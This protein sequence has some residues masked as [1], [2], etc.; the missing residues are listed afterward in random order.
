M[1]TPNGKTL[2]VHFFT[3]IFEHVEEI[4]QFQVV[5]HAYDDIEIRYIPSSCFNSVCLNDIKKE[6]WNK[7]NEEFQLRFSKVDFIAPSPSGKPQIVESKLEFR[8]YYGVPK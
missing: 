1:Y 7:A 4:R 5:Q 6:I 3:G 8:N 2:V